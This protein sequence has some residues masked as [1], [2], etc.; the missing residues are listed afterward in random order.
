MSTWHQR[1]RPVKF[2]HE[3]LWTLVNNP[4]NEMTELFT[5]KTEA[6]AKVWQQYRP[7][8]YIL[9]PSNPVEVA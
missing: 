7:H 6:E 3:T 1:R 5:F 9:K 4:P 2:Y 8:S